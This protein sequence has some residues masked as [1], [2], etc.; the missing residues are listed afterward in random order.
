[1]KTRGVLIAGNWKMN[2]GPKE[3]EGFFSYLRG[4]GAASLPANALPLFHGGKLR[5]T[6]IPPSIDLER[7]LRA[8]KELATDA[9][10]PITIATQNAHWELK[11]AFTGELSGPMLQE[12]G[13]SSALVG[14]SER[15]QYF[16]E[17]D[18]TVRKRADSLL[19]Q[20][21]EII[22]CIGETKDERLAGDTEKV[23][24]KQIDQGISETAAQSPK[25]VIAY[26]PVWAIGTGLTATP[27]QAQ[28]AHAFIRTHLS[29]RFGEAVA[30]ARPLLYG[31]SVTPENVDSLL[32]CPDVDGGLVGG[33]SLKP[34]GFL[35]LVAAGARALG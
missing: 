23:L 2:Y 16:G 31:G 8:A 28:E 22:L 7:A 1:M 10:F 20:G 6:L 9:S 4:R 30:T 5:A 15:R 25:L 14:H 27:E 34:E 12:I 35:A 17:T 26:E 11:G 24:A 13:I 29:K 18:E 21:F 33:A 3:T 32:A 19:K